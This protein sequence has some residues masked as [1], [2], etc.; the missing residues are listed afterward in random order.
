MSDSTHGRLLRHDIAARDR[1]AV[2]AYAQ[3]LTSANRKLQGGYI[4]TVLVT[5]HWLVTI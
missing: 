3:G 1:T 2:V 4:R 5:K